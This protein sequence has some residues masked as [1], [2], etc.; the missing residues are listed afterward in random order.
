MHGAAATATPCSPCSQ[1]AHGL[2][3]HLQCTTGRGAEAV[4]NYPIIRRRLKHL[5]THTETARNSACDNGCG[6]R[7]CHTLRASCPWGFAGLECAVSSDGSPF[8]RAWQGGP[9]LTNLVFVARRRAL[10]IHP[11]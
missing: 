2:A 9:S 5:A 8:V 1:T 3:P 6:L 11:Y 4:G 10:H 7:G